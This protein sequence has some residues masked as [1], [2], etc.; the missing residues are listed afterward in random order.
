MTDERLLGAYF[1][2]NGLVVW[3]LAVFSKINENSFRKNLK[4]FQFVNTK[5]VR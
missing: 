5:E 2:L 1:F 3:R 4:H